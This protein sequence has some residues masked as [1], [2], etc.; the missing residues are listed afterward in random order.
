MKRALLVASGV[1]PSQELLKKLW[2]LCELHGCADGGYRVVRDGGWIPEILLGDFDSLAELPSA[3]ALEKEGTSL[4]TLPREKDLTDTEALVEEFLSLGVEEIVL[5]GVLGSRW[6]HSLANI[7]I[8]ERL[9]HRGVR[10]EI[11][12]ENCHIWLFG[13]GEHLVSKDGF[14]VVSL[15]PWTERARVSLHGFHYEITSQELLRGTGRGVSNILKVE[16][17]RIF[18]EEGLVLLIQSSDE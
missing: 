16:E 5:T 2:P 8:L 9:Y 3:F 7:G 13:P 15:L 17:G 6:D 10:G 14:A 1:P 11:F 18:V 12:G 4:I